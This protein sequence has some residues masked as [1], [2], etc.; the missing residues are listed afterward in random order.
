MPSKP[1]AAVIVLTQLTHRGLWE[2]AKEH[3]AYACLHKHYTSADDLDSAIRSGGRWPW[4]GIC[5]KKIGT[6]L[7]CD[8]GHRW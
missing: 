8:A 5:P 4:S 7:T 3:G 1:R 2:L 6:G